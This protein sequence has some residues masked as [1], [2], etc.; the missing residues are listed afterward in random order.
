[1]RLSWGKRSMRAKLRWYM[2]HDAGCVHC[3]KCGTAIYDLPLAIEHGARIPRSLRRFIEH[4]NW[5]LA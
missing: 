5:R 4:P 2:V 1:M 3:R